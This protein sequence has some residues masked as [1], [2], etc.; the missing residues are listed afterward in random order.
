MDCTGDTKQVWTECGNVQVVPRCFAAFAL[1]LTIMSMMCDT[2]A[3]NA[4]EPKLIYVSCL[5]S[6]N[7]GYDV[8]CL[9]GNKL[10]TTT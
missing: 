3:W 2:S 10:M 6:C 5:T 9:I 1:F 4:K 7:F 8:D